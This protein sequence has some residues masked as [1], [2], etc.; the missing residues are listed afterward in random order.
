MPAAIALDC[1]I[2]V[3]ER[4]GVGYAVPPPRNPGRFGDGIVIAVIP[5]SVGPTF[6]RRDIPVFRHRLHLLCAA[7]S[8]LRHAGSLLIKLAIIL[9][10]TSSKSLYATTLAEVTGEEHASCTQ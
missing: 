7:S 1:I 5:D 6:V 9:T 10:G 2:R 4:L 8:P 3:T